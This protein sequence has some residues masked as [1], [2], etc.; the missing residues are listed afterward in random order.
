MNFHDAWT[1]LEQ[2][3]RERHEEVRA[4]FA[5]GQRRFVIW[6]G[7]ERGAVPGELVRERDGRWLARV[8]GNLRYADSYG[9]IGEPL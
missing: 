8:D 7:L 9:D 6:A 3:R 5:S 4:I 2:R 1:E